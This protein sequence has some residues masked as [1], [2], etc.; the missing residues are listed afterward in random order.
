MAFP[1]YLEIKHP[2]RDIRGSVKAIGKEDLIL[3]VALETML[4]DGRRFLE[5][6]VEEQRRHD[7]YMGFTTMKVTMESGPYIPLLYRALCYREELEEAVL[8][9][10]KV[11]KKTH[12]EYV[13]FQQRLYPLRVSRVRMWF[14]NVKG[15]EYE[16]YP[17]MAEVWFRYRYL[18]TV[19]VRGYHVSKVEWPR[20][21]SEGLCERDARILEDML[22]G[23]ALTD[24]LEYDPEGRRKMEEG[25][26]LYSPSWRHKDEGLARDYPEEA[27]EGE[28]IIL[29]C[30][31]ENVSEGEWVT[32]EIE[33]REEK[34]NPI[35]FAS[36]SGKVKGGVASGEWKV[37]L[38]RLR[39]KKDKKI[40]E[41]RYTFTARYG[42]IYSSRSEIKLRGEKIRCDFVEIPDILFH[43]GSAVPCLDDSGTLISSLVTTLT[44]A[45][46]NPEKEVILF[47][48]ADTSG[49][50]D[51]NYDLSGWRA[52]GVKALLDNDVDAWHDIID[53]A[54]KVEDY[55]A[56]L[57]ALS[58]AYG[59]GCDPGEVDNLN[60]P[61]TRAAVK[62]FQE[63]YNRRYGGELKPDGE[64]G[65][66]T[67][68][69]VFTVMRNILTSAWEARTKET[70]LPKL[71][72]G[73]NGKGVYP[74]GESFPIEAAEKDNYKSATN[75]RVEIV[76]FDKGQA[77]ALKEPADRKKVEKTEA[78]V[79]D[80][81]RVEKRRIPVTE[82][83]PES[84]EIIVDLYEYT[85]LKGTA[86]AN[87]GK[88]GHLIN[89]LCKYHTVPVT[90][91]K[92]GY[93]NNKWVYVFKKKGDSISLW[94]EC[95]AVVQNNTPS[96]SFV[97]WVEGDRDSNIKS[98]PRKEVKKS[99][100]FRL[101]P[102]TEYY[103]LLSGIQLPFARIDWYIKNPSRLAE[104]SLFV[105]ANELKPGMRAPRL[106]LTEYIEICYELAGEY[107][108]AVEKHEGFVGDETKT[109]RYYL[110]C[111]I[112]ATSQSKPRLKGWLDYAAVKREID[113]YEKDE[114]S[115]RSRV[116]S[117]RSLLKEWK[118][119]PGFQHTRDDYNGYKEIEEAILEHE[120]ALTSIDEIEYLVAEMEN[121][122]SWYNTIV[123]N[124]PR[125]KFFSSIEMLATTE[126]FADFF[127]KYI[128]GQYLANFGP[129]KWK[130][131]TT[132]EWLVQTQERF[133]N[134]IHEIIERGKITFPDLVQ[135]KGK[136]FFVAFD[137]ETKVPFID[138]EFKGIGRISGRTSLDTMKYRAARRKWNAAVDKSLPALQTVLVGIETVNLVNSV[139]TLLKSKGFKEKG[140]SI[141]E[142]VGS[143][144]DFLSSLQYLAEKQLASR[145]VPHGMPK[146]LIVKAAKKTF[147]KVNLAGAVCNYIGA[148]KDS[149]EAA[150]KGYNRTS[151]GYSVIALASVASGVAAITELSGAAIF[152]LTAGPLGVIG[153]ALLIVGSGILWYFSD[154]ELQVWAENCSYAKKPSFSPSL[155]TQI[156]KL[157]EI[158]C[159]FD[160]ACYLYA[161]KVRH[162]LP[163]RDL[164]AD[165]DY[166]FT[167]RIRPGYINKQKSKYHVTV[168]IYRKGGL[169]GK[170]TLVLDRT[171]ILPDSRTQRE[172]Y[173]AG[174][175]LQ[176]LIRRFSGKELGLPENFYE[177]EYRYELTAALDLDGDGKADFP[178]GGKTIKGNVKI[179]GKDL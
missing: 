110:A 92:T 68:E 135:N 137:T 99:S 58:T 144:A 123:G 24:D 176:M 129:T 156:E 56:T 140:L 18:E 107:H 7:Y 89:G 102:D 63:E 91:S 148:L 42:S 168:K 142:V 57:K 151:A 95:K 19:F 80:V 145:K 105:P 101:S 139:D 90:G 13:Y 51:Y 29:S 11:D 157:H 146:E 170:D 30:E 82:S 163:A 97:S 43:H 173:D 138:Y 118:L 21:Y 78:P 4:M 46:D 152:G 40:E 155:D 54:S 12:R 73:Y 87:G 14:P 5:L 150:S 20:F 17:H 79:Y 62:A 130:G 166:W 49:N 136:W 60:G 158:I 55:Q 169:L 147:A 86:E 103:I 27:A 35:H 44:F 165:Y 119:S 2:R 134:H 47:G 98:Y 149:A 112:A 50:P 161:Q 111:L 8:Y 52:E 48:H 1:V 132:V 154:E 100:E 143:G 162:Y 64:M 15:A 81:K 96:F 172:P 124:D 72:Y 108:E 28:V 3:G 65:S 153:I 22:R 178:K 116:E 9:F 23:P 76:F 34:G 115:L 121:K 141:I 32:F 171:L 53:H 26:S 167:V 41:L 114:N 75:R 159:L 93:V 31:T 125:F 37:D 61:R 25:I 33:Y 84:E 85:S 67:W 175:P 128:V 71:T 70:T 74:C 164:P 109:K 127:K 94:S 77:P 133:L 38:G 179:T 126:Q 104:R 39:K 117:L 69:A 131:K 59:W 36:S 113:S 88:F 106:Y 177:A 174:Q 120:A 122:E 160:T 45:R 16:R 66:K 6:P 10:P 83:K